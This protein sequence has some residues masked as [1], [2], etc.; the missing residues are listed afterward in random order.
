MWTTV[1]FHH[2]NTNRS[3]PVIV[4]RQPP[5]SSSITHSVRARQ[6]SSITASAMPT[7]TSTALRPRTSSTVSSRSAVQDGHTASGTRA[8][9]IVDVFA[10]YRPIPVS[11]VVGGE[12]A[13]GARRP[14]PPPLVESLPLTMFFHCGNRLWL[15]YGGS[16]VHSTSQQLPSL[17]HS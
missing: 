9:S 1:H 15:G 4:Q 12:T 2:S 3:G 6:Y 8:P 16:P 14:R 11:L 17:P 5:S 13:S 7:T 10:G